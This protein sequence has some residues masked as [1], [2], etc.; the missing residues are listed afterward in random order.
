MQERQTFKPDRP[1][2]TRE[3]RVYDASNSLQLSGRQWLALAGLAIAFV[4]LSPSLW[5]WIEPF[6]AEADYRMPYALGNDYG[7]YDRFT[8]EAASRCEAMLVGD[9]VVWGA[10]VT[11]TQTLSHALNAL[12]GRERFANLGL[13]GAHPAALAGLIEHHASGLRGKTV[14][15]ACNLLWMSSPRHDLRE[16]AEFD[17]NHP[18]LVPQFVPRIPC[19]RADAATRL[20]RVIDRNSRFTTWTYH[21]QQAYFGSMAIPEWTLEHPYDCPLQAAVQ[22]LPLSDNKL[23]HAPVAWTRQGMAAQDFPWV[24]P[25]TSLQWQSF[26]RAIEILRRRDNRVIVLLCP[27][28]EHMLTPAS[29]ERFVDVRAA[30]MASLD[31]TGV[32]VMAPSTLPSDFY[33]DASHPLDA[34][35]RRLAG[36]MMASG[37]IP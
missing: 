15:L 6:P 7:F 28:N 27:F 32:P 1:A 22:P 19:Y 13:D 9:S 11:R 8:R 3:I 29:R 2:T 24:D 26:R 36:D 21:L 4:A 10:Y 18:G 25:A 34:G 16:S 37:K 30:V 12:A 17:F 35:Y 20:G 33:A 5:T 23:R 31:A 14:V